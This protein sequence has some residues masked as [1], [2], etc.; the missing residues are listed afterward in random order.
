[1]KKLS[2]KWRF[3]SLLVK[4]LSLAIT[5]VLCLVHSIFTFERDSSLALSMVTLI[6]SCVVSYV[7]H[8]IIHE[9]GHLVFG[10]LSGYKFRSFRILSFML[11][12]QDGKIKLKRFSLA[13]TL[14]QCLLAPPEM[15]D[16]KCPTFWYNMG[17]VIFNLITSAIAVA[18]IFV[19]INVPYL[20]LGLLLFVII[21]ISTA[22]TNGIPMRTKIVDNDGYNAF[23]LSKNDEARRAFWIQLKVGEQGACGVRLKDMPD[24]WFELPSDE[25]MKNSM[26]AVL[27]VLKANRLLDEIKLDE[28][29]RLMAHLTSIDSGI[30]NLHRGLLICD[31]I[32]CEL[33][34]ENRKEFVD[35]L[36]TREQE[37]FISSMKSYISVI[38]MQYAYALFYENDNEK[39]EKLLS[40]FEKVSKTYPNPSDI[41]SEKELIS[42]ANER[43][44]T[45][46]ETE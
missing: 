21:G 1:M 15:K 28:A 9:G 16:G 8:I 27:G 30:V 44:N 37:S 22:L 29:E 14:G 33:I 43:Y 23:S 31:R 12:K 38:R 13:G 10:L 5:F 18:L 32:Y 46:K 17:G 2:F 36:L 26:I 20:S 34:G 45:E 4:I 40:T 11:I 19:F 39:A 41:E 35:S 24:E 7:L 6:V 25:A 42:I 3:I